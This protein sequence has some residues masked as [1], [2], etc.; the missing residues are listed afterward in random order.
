MS[1]LYNVSTEQ[2]PKQ[3]GGRNLSFADGCLDFGSIVEYLIQCKQVPIAKMIRLMGT[4]KVG[5]KDLKMTVGV[6]LQV[7]LKFRKKK[8]ESD[9]EKIKEQ[10]K[11]KNDV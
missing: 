6:N 11:E 2:K 1:T 5:R 9:E 10:K 7:V 4:N 3:G 8:S